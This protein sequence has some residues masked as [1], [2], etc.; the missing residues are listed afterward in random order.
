M[1]PTPSLGARLWPLAILGLAI[2]AVRY[3]LEFSRAEATMYFGVYYAMPLAF[4]VIGVGGL[5]GRI[6]WPALLGTVA[7]LC[8][9]V[10]GIPNTV[11]YTTGQFLEWHH[12]R[13]YYGGPDDPANRAAPVAASALS[14]I[15]WGALQGLL[16]AVAGTIWCTLWAT[17]LIWLPAKLRERSA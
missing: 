13:F 14:K 4:L 3:A 6:R 8:L 1:R 17:A 10:W 15:G 16:T 7:L 2:G 12:G 9:I 5:W 11:A